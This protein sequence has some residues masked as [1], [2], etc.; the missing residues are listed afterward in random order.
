MSIPSNWRVDCY[1]DTVIYHDTTADRP[2]APKQQRQPRARRVA[3][4]AAD[5]YRFCRDYEVSPDHRDRA[6]T[7]AALG[8]RDLSVTPC[9]VGWFTRTDGN[10]PGTWTAEELGIQARQIAGFYK[11]LPDGAAC[12]YV[13]SDLPASRVQSTVLHELKHRSQVA[14][15][16]YHGTPHAV[17]EADAKSYAATAVKRFERPIHDPRMAG[18]IL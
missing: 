2:K 16:T 7:A 10:G 6:R 14:T 13:R 11:E 18:R 8:T 3:D 17:R 5:R 4:P 15:G 9:P 12:V 1:G